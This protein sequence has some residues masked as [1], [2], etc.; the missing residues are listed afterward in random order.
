MT[1][2][3]QPARGV[4]DG[5]LHRYAVEVYYEDTDAGGVTYHA[6][7]LRWF[8]RART[9]ILRLLGIDQR[10]AVD[11][12]VGSYIVAEAK[13]KYLR[14]ARLGDTIVI[15]SSC[16]QAQSAS[17][18]MTQFAMRGK[19]RLVEGEV[20]VGFVGPDGRPRRQPADWREKFASLV[21]EE[22]M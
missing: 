18:R 5:K 6:T 4:I 11:E 20:R 19:E 21:C 2:I 13:L 1:A 16:E 7:Y 17:V 14:P 15:E 22:T 12:G 10:A 3:P 9:D 8:E